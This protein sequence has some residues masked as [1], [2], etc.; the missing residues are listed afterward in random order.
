[1]KGE[2]K[3]PPVEWHAVTQKLRERARDHKSLLEVERMGSM[4]ARMTKKDAVK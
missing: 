1:M 3:V 2:P 4:L